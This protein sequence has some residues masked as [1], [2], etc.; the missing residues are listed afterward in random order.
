M[1]TYLDTRMHMHIRT[2]RYLYVNKEIKQLAAGTL[3]D[4]ILRSS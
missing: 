1:S 2:H 3:Q 4:F